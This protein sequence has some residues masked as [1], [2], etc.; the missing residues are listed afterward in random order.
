MLLS[1]SSFGIVREEKC[2]VNIQD[3]TTGICHTWRELSLVIIVDTTKRTLTE[4][5]RYGDCDARKLWY[6]S[7]S[8]YRTCLTGCV[9]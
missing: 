9:I 7:G 3:V 5:E 2:E 6:S 8:T 1:N 4:V